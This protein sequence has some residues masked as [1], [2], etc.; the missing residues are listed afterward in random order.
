VN[1]VLKVLP[2]DQAIRVFMVKKV[3][4]VNMVTKENE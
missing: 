3:I 4:V 1:V 2:D